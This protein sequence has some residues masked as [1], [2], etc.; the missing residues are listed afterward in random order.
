MSGEEVKVLAAIIAQ[1]QKHIVSL[2]EAV[3]LKIGIPANHQILSATA[4]QHIS[5]AE[6]AKVCDDQQT[7]IIDQKVV[8]SM[9]Y[10]SDPISI[11]GGNTQIVAPESELQNSVPANFE[12]ALAHQQYEDATDKILFKCED[13]ARVSK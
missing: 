8:S 7:I 1:N 3:K 2:L 5:V 12:A 9:E 4:A 13:T 11:S 6:T 10:K